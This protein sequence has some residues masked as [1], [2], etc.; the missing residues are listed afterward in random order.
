MPYFSICEQQCRND[1]NFQ[2]ERLKYKLKKIENLNDSMTDSEDL[3]DLAER[4]LIT[5]TDELYVKLDTDFFGTLD[6]MEA[7]IETFKTLLEKQDAK[8][9]KI[10]EVYTKETDVEYSKLLKE[11]SNILDR[12]SKCK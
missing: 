9:Q 8:T 5:L 4:N 12:C 3:Y 11:L 10:N 1:V 6:E 2:L 7:V